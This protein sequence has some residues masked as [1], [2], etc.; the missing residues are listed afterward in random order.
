[1]VLRKKVKDEAKDI[2]GVMG[3]AENYIIRNFMICR[4]SGNKMLVA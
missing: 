2:A 1:L 3:T 4:L